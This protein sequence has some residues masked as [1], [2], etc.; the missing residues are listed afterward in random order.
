MTPERFNL[1]YFFMLVVVGLEPD[2]QLN[3]T[4]LHKQNERNQNQKN[5]EIKPWC[6][7]NG[8]ENEN[9]M[10]GNNQNNNQNNK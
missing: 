8:M 5:M 3:T 9:K 4:T 10:I 1:E 2:Q 6:W 7:S